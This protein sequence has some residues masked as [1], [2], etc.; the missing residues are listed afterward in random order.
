[1]SSWIPEYA[2]GR[3]RK[4][5]AEFREWQAKFYKSREWLELAEQIRLDRNMRSDYSGSIIF[6]LS[7]VDH[8][9]EITPDNKDDPNITLNPDNLQLL[10]IEEH[11]MKTA[12]TLPPIIEDEFDFSKRKDTLF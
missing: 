12:G 2:P 6:G 10:S 1:M 3:E 7:A 4:W 9:I 8:I 5:P 11:N